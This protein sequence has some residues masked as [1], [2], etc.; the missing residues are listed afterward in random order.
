MLLGADSGLGAVWVCGI[1]QLVERVPELVVVLCQSYVIL[2][3]HSL[4]LCVET[5]YHH[6]LEAVALHLEPVFHLV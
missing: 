2:L 1:E 4:E 5:A 6:V 3:I